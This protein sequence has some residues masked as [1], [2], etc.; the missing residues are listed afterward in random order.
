MSNVFLTDFLRKIF[1][2]SCVV[3]KGLKGGS[4]KIKFIFDLQPQMKSNCEKFQIAVILLHSQQ[5][6]SR[7]GYKL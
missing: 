4:V 6:S 1:A 2:V 5:E 3:C 7:F